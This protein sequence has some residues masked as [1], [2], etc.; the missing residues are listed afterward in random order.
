MTF[1]SLST[2][3]NSFSAPVTEEHAWALIHQVGIFHFDFSSTMLGFC[4]GNLHCNG[5]VSQHLSHQAVT[6][7][8]SLLK[9]SELRELFTV[10][11]TEVKSAKM[12]C[13]R[14]QFYVRLQD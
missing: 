13:F 5:G 6:T 3:L 9:T 14:C 8:Q 4:L 12:C 2:L 1:T 11:G 7:L 10:G